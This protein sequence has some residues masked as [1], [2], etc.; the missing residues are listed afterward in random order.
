M[1]ASLLHAV[2]Q[3]VAGAPLFL[4]LPTTPNEWLF[5]GAVFIGAMAILFGVHPEAVLGVMYLGLIVYFVDVLGPHPLFAAII[6]GTAALARLAG[7]GGDKLRNWVDDAGPETMAAV[8]G[9]LQHIVSNRGG[10][11]EDD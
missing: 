5:I 1:A 8:A 2:L 7:V 6:I 9:I 4:P 3:P 11:R 10:G